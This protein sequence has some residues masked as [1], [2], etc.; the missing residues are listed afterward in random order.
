L[1]LPAGTRL[2]PYEILSPLGSGGMG[3]VYRARDSRL[4]RDV[5]V[6]VLPERIAVDPDALARFEREARAVAAL[7]HP[8][9]LGIFDFG[10]E[11]STTY[12]VSELLEG[13]TLRERLAGGP[14][15]ARKAV[16]YGAQIARGLAAAHEK[17]I[18][19]R[20]V[21][22]E[23]VF[24]TS[25]GRIKI[26]DFGLAR[27]TA[28]GAGADDTRSPTVAGGTSP[29]MVMGTVGYMSPEQVRGAPADHRSDIFS[30]GSVLYEMLTG[31]RAFGRA[32]GA[33]TMTAILKEDPPDLSDSGADLSP[34]LAETVRHCLEKNPAERFQSARDLAFDLEHAV[35]SSA[36]S[37]YA[38]AAAARRGPRILSIA[39][40]SLAALAFLAA[41]GLLAT[42]MR[43]A[44]EPV[45]RQLTYHRGYVE[46]ARFSPDGQTVIYGS[47]RR[48]QPVKIYSARL[49]SI[50]STPLDL[51]SGTVLGISRT[52]EMAILL[53][54]VHR[55]YWIRS[56][57]LARVPL[58]GGAPREVLEHVTDGDISGDGQALAVVREI[59]ARQRL[60]FP[61]GKTILETDGYIDHPRISS[62]GGSVAFLEHPFYGNDAGYVAVARSGAAGAERLT[63]LQSGL[64]GLSWSPDGKEIW[65]TGNVESAETKDNGTRY[66]LWAVRPGRK[67]RSVYVPP[68]NL[69]I[70]DVSRKGTI[71]L[72]GDD[73]RGEIGGFLKGDARERDLS[74]WSDEALSAIAEDGAGY[75]GIEQSAPGAGIDPFLYYRRAGDSAPVRLGSGTGI[76]LSPDGKWIANVQRVNETARLTLVPTGAGDAVPIDLGAVQPR[77]ASHERASFSADGMR[78]LFPGFEPNRRPRVWLID[79]PKGRPTAV[80]PE[81]ESLALLSP[82]GGSVAGVDAKGR[83]VMYRLAEGR[84]SPT[85]VHGAL[86]YERPIQWESSGRALFVWDRTW[87]ARI[88]RVELATGARTIWKELAPDPVGVLYG[89][90]VLT[91]DGKHYVYRIRRVL[92][93]LNLAEGLK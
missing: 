83:I 89:N 82:D 4:G 68:M 38:A 69:R 15:P 2:G 66:S 48:D 88:A 24:V 91:P 14:I 70:H 85:E 1:T 19:H 20:D 50:E 72:S 86:A 42:R 43:H 80:T 11:G 22:P 21:K 16:E 46:S 37:R 64:D 63:A 32:T 77:V 65:F 44:R 40:S 78:F 30:F 51:P 54:C 33:E 26:L 35:G 27:Q 23:N 53:G 18:V 62:D 25:D 92:S 29:G 74:T 75:L 81:G 60:E 58:G 73:R 56:G 93:E 49:D 57:T 45:F 7:S 84:G 13:E 79:L 17:G 9:I 3:E 71:L 90:I 61:L 87:P 59:G 39:A 8:N 47:T 6:K 36:P 76:A 28:F 12:S 34:S 55:G 52:G 31:R 41:G 10:S 67:P 5:A